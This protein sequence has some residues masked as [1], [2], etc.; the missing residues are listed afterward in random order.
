MAFYSKDADLTVASHFVIKQDSL[1]QIFKPFVAQI[2][3]TGGYV[4]MDFVQLQY[5]ERKFLE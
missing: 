3:K 4:D 2:D 5:C 1:F